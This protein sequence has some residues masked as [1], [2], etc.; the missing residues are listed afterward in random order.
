[1][2]SVPEAA[3]DSPPDQVIPLNSLD[4]QDYT[5]SEHERQSLFARIEKKFKHLSATAKIIFAVAVA[6]ALLF[7]LIHNLISS[8]EK[9]ISPEKI[10]KL[11]NLLL[12][13]QT[14]DS[15]ICKFNSKLCP[16]STSPNPNSPSN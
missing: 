16:K 11:I 7:S 8:D 13:S 15:D 4:K 2:E 1:M 12:L 5:P 9:D 14:I 6:I 10:Q 3:L